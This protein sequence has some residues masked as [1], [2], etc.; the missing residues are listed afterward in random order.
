MAF[1]TSLTNAVDGVTDVIAA[2]L[3]NLE[4][5]VGIDDSLVTTSLDYLLKNPASVSPGHRHVNLYKSDGS[6]VAVAVDVNGNVG[7]GTTPGAKLESLST[8]EPLRLSYDGTY[9]WKFTVNSGN[10]VGL[11]LVP[12][13]APN[14]VA[15]GDPA[16]TA[17][18]S[19]LVVQA[20]ANGQ[21][22]VITYPRTAANNTLWH[23]PSHGIGLR[24]TTA[25]GEL[26]GVDNLSFSVG[27]FSN[28]PGTNVK[29]T[30]LS[31]GN[32][33]IGIASPITAALLHLSSTTKGFLPPVMTTA[34]KTAISSPPAGLMVYD[35][36]LHK[37]CVYTGAAWET[38]A[39]A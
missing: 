7:I 23:Q 36:T 28:N 16:D 37:L 15:I 1:P 17:N 21:G 10:N 31:S 4:A 20:A 27:A 30:I 2:H 14:Y 25:I 29:M 19:G 9:Y 6:A 13:A 32:V 5:K 35:S 22:G 33:G 18:Y 24:S 26:N 12:A 8:T 3:N 38:I 34:Q 11:K 39:S